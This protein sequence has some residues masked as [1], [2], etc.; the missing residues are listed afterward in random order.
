M[1]VATPFH[2]TDS[3]ADVRP[4]SMLRFDPLLVLA[5]L[6][7]LACSLVTLKGATRVGLDLRLRFAVAGEHGQVVG[8]GRVRGRSGKRREQ[9]A[10]QLRP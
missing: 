10:K 5:A 1:S 8:P 4:R 7:L 3:V 6:G 2:T 9:L